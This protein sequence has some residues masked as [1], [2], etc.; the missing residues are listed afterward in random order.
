MPLNV[1]L[2]LLSLLRLQTF[3]W[4]RFDRQGT[5]HKRIDRIKNRIRFDLCV[6]KFLIGDCPNQ[7]SEQVSTSGRRAK[8]ARHPI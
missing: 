6:I 1:S 8:L 3:F 5:H 2:D 4:S 7:A